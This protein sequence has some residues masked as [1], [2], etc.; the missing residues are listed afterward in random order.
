VDYDP[1]QSEDSPT[2]D[3]DYMQTVLFHLHASLGG[4]LWNR[5]LQMDRN[6]FH[7]QTSNHLIKL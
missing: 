6:F 4:G 5:G 2:V 3:A 7:P 1:V